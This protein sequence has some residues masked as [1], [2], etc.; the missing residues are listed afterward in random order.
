METWTIHYTCKNYHLWH[1]SPSWAIAFLG[2]PDN[3]IFTDTKFM[4]Q[5]HWLKVH[6][7]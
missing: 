6:Q 3:G 2:F 7:K 5:T 1:D 4:V